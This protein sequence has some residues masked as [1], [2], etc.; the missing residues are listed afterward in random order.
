MPAAVCGKTIGRSMMPSIARLPGKSRRASRY[1]SGT[2][3]TKP[4]AVVMS[5][6]MTVRTSERRTSS[7]RRAS[8]SRP[9]PAP[10]I[11]LPAGSA[12]KVTSTTP[13][14]AQSAQNREMRRPGIRAG[15]TDVGG[16]QGLP[17]A[18]IPCRRRAA[19]LVFDI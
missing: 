18:C 5:A 4:M 11:M 14:T 15:E 7:C 9:A 3:K 19:P 2:P 17:G 6:A 13:A 1:A 10:T 16:A 12:T 8:P